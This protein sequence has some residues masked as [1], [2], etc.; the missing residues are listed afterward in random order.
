MAGPG[1][2]RGLYPGFHRLELRHCTRLE[3][4]TG[5]F[6]SAPYADVHLHTVLAVGCFMSA[7]ESQI[8]C[9]GCGKSVPWKPE[10]VGKRLKC[11]CGFVIVGPPAAP[12]RVAAPAAKAANVRI[13][14]TP[15]KAN[16]PPPPPPAKPAADVDDFDALVAQA[17]EYAVAE[18]ATKP[19]ARPKPVRPAAVATAGG[20]TRPCWPTPRSSAQS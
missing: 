6:Q 1:S 2:A 18:E 19:K 16:P 13:P 17:E 11:K 7:I 3:L 5:L 8:S 14:A 15:P 4:T 9:G 10:Y 12:A 20:P